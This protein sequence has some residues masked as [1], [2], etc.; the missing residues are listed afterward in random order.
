MVNF[1]KWQ[2]LVS[3]SLTTAGKAIPQQTQH[4]PS[5]FWDSDGDQRTTKYKNR[6][7]KRAEVR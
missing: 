1:K 2:P 3:S 7:K 6:R 5:Y 4:I